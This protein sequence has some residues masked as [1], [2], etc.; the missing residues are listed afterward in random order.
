MK[1]LKL[2]STYRNI[3]MNVASKYGMV[4][5]NQSTTKRLERVHWSKGI[6]NNLYYPLELER[7]FDEI[8]RI[9]IA[10]QKQIKIKSLLA[11]WRPGDDVIVPHQVHA[12][13][14]ERMENLDDD[15]Y[16]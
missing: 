2:V 7:N 3:K 4:Q 11:N 16:C 6:K 1:T 13:A 12:G 8:K 10:L 14:K 15:K 9:I 5:P